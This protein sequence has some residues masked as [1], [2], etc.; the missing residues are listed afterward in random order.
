MLMAS[1][2]ACTTKDPSGTDDIAGD[3]GGSD[4]TGTGETGTGTDGCADTG[5]T[6]TGNDPGCTAPYIAT[7]LPTPPPLPIASDEFFALPIGGYLRLTRR[8][9]ATQTVLLFAG[10]G[11]DWPTA[12]SY[13]QSA[14]PALDQVDLAVVELLNPYGLA[15]NRP[16][17][18]PAMFVGGPGESPFVT[19]GWTAW[20]GGDEYDPNT[21]GAYEPLI[22]TGDLIE[23]VVGDVDV[24]VQLG[25]EAGSRSYDCGNNI[26]N[27]NGHTVMAWGSEASF[28]LADALA[29]TLATTLEPDWSAW[30][31]D[32]PLGG[33]F[34]YD[35]PGEA[36]ERLLG[37]AADWVLKEWPGA[38][39]IE[40]ILP[41]NAPP[42]DCVPLLAGEPE[43]APWPDVG[44]LRMRSHVERAAAVSATLWALND[45]LA[46]E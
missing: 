40:V 19:W 36:S 14:P 27:C 12:S 2:L 17:I 22:L 33:G 39:V 10:L 11:G 5:G 9:G 42:S 44:S 28:D 30:H 38:R 16:V 1:S 6:D 45:T 34:I 8:T 46:G 32:H 41:V 3:T 21:P 7:P 31:P 20:D 18:D 4:Q 15:A 35:Q 37:T 26:Y 24:F 13:I 29:T 23:S 25:K 43:P